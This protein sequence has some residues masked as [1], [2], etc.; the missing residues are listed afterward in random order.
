MVV[1]VDGSAL[2]ID[3]DF[4]MRTKA[5]WFLRYEFVCKIWRREARPEIDQATKE[6]VDRSLRESLDGD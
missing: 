1:I 4:E 2:Q 6:L 5:G 3:V